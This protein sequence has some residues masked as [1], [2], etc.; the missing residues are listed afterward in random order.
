MVG[1][2]SGGI[3]TALA[4][5]S[6]IRKML[7]EIAAGHRAPDKLRAAHDYQNDHVFPAITG[8]LAAFAA[9]LDAREQAEVTEERHVLQSAVTNIDQI[10]GCIGLIAV[11]ASIEAARAGDAGRGFSV[12]ASEIQQLSRKSRDVLTGIRGQLS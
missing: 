1:E 3:A 9:A 6:G 8:F 10:N 7:Q 4:A 2:L 5:V 11:N 12:I